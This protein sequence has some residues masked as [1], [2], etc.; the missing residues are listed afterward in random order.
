LRLTC[1][2]KG[3]WE[4]KRLAKIAWWLGDRISSIKTIELPDVRNVMHNLCETVPFW[5]WDNR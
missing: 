3:N 2:T 1:G 4:S 5:F